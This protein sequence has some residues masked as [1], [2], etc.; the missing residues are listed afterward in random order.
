LTSWVEVVRDESKATKGASAATLLVPVRDKRCL[1]KRRGRNDLGAIRT[2][3]KCL[4][5]P[6]DVKDSRRDDR[7]KR[8]DGE[9]TVKRE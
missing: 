6:G 1:G 8:A 9:V 3:L 5:Y 2:R 7:G 4:S